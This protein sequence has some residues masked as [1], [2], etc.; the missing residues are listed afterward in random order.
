MAIV[1]VGG[2]SQNVGKTSVAAG[3]IAAFPRCSWTAIKI[4]SHRHTDAAGNVTE[5]IHEERDPHGRGDTSRFLA[6][7][8]SRSLWVRM[9][10][11]NAESIMQRLLP[12]T[13]SN[14][15]VIIESNRILHFIRP[16]LCIFVLRYDIGDFKASAGEAILQANAIVAVNSGSLPPA[17]K[18]FPGEV[19]DGIPLFATDDPQR[20]PKGLIDFVRSRLQ[21]PIGKK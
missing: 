5:E 9:G 19:L 3:L 8:A 10:E 17:W 21:V 6:A 2:H 12:V 20:I 13:Q 14:S 7:G 16:D 15:Y 11:S 1:V 4:S 18:G